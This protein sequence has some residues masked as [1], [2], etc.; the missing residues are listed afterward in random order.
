MRVCRFEVIQL[1]EKP[2]ENQALYGRDNEYTENQ[3]DVE[4]FD[5]SEESE[6]TISDSTREDI[7]HLASM[8]DQYDGEAL[9]TRI[10]EDSFE[11]E[12]TIRLVL[13]QE[14]LI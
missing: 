14:G 4:P 2:L 3:E 13:E 7:L 9:V 12:E 1:C 5:E 10:G 6:D 8:H 11:D